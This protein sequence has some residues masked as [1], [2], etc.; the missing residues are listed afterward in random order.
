MHARF[1]IA[2][3]ACHAI[4]CL[5]VEPPAS[6][7]SV[8]IRLT[9]S[10]WTG[11]P[12]SRGAL[13][14]RPHLALIHTHPLAPATDAVLLLRGLD[15]KD[16]RSSLSHKPLRSD[17]LERSVPC[18]VV[19]E[20]SALSITPHDALDP[21]MPYTLAVASWERSLD[22]VALGAAL[23]ATFGLTTESGPEAGARVL[24]SFPADGAVSVG[25][26]LEAA[27]IA[28]DGDVA[29]GAEGVW[30]QGPDGL[31]VP[32]QAAEGPC[33]E[34]AEEHDGSACVKL[35]PTEHL[36]PDALYALA[37]GTA[38]LDAHGAPI[39]PF[40]ATFRTA[41]GS[42]W[43]APKTLPLACS[44]DEQALDVGCVLFDDE[45]VTVRVRADEA[46]TA[47]LIAS[48]TRAVAVAPNGELALRLTDLSPDARFD[49]TL[50]MRDIAGNVTEH[51]VSLR[52]LPPL[53]SVSIVE[54][55]ADP[56]GAEPAQEL[57]E[58]LN[59]GTAPVDI[60][61]FALDA[62]AVAPVPPLGRSFVMQPGT[63]V[64]LVSDDFD[65]TDARDA[66]PPPGAP[67]LRMGR[68]L[69]GSGLSNAGS[70]LCLHDREGQR[71]SAAPSTP[72]PRPGVCN[73][74][75]STDMRDG[76]PGTFGYDAHDTCT[77]GR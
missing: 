45:S 20:G 73:V 25:T 43:Q 12:G 62:C 67:L 69:A 22:G 66:R 30:L 42:D 47:S 9:A 65:P 48:A 52:T 46:V 35:V 64:L 26:N 57:V 4:A 63:R 60:E 10:D 29:N 23:P 55:R 6:P 50:R 59:Y 33:A 27:V 77:P 39:G 61:G 54:V 8:Q 3:A 14:L 41:A 40:T 19:R 70:R 7:S 37:V 53:A 38:A 31:A 1:G 15:S 76:S 28:F 13:P 32:V 51:T 11:I 58:L 68:A 17:Y 74:R 34:L 71:V 18:D 75:I 56:L 72:R 36:A 16:L 2:F 24:E 5:Q 49:A 21:G 44:S